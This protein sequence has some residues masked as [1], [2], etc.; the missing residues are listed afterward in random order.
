[1]PASLLDSQ[2]EA[3]DAPE[4]ATVVDAREP[5]DSIVARIV[6]ALEYKS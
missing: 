1:M 3:L 5:V 6:V 4:D 2:L